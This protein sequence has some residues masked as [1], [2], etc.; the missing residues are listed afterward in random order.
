MI[1]YF[2]HRCNLDTFVFIKKYNLSFI[3]WKEAIF[4]FYYD[5][6]TSL[7]ATYKSLIELIGHWENKQIENNPKKGIKRKLNISYSSSN[8]RQKLENENDEKKAGI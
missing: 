4:Q 6:K 5:Q 8:K 2:K 3:L 1:K 7:K